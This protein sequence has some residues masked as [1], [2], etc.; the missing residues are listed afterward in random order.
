MPRSL[1]QNTN[2]GI[3]S[4]VSRRPMDHVRAWGC[5]ACVRRHKTHEM[6]AMRRGQRDMTRKPSARHIY[7]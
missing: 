5:I 7:V 4:N 2:A 6:G 3:R 1:S